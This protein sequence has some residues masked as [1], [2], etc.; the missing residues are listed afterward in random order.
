MVRAVG[1]VPDP[2]GRVATAPRRPQ[3]LHTCVGRFVGQRTDAVGLA[4][5]GSSM[6]SFFHALW[7]VWF[8][9]THPS[10]P[11]QRNARAG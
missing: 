1:R 10:A 4:G 5:Y 6:R 8:S 11:G 2:W 7:P 9:P 3:P